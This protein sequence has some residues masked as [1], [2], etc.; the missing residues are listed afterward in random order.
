MKFDPTSKKLLWIGIIFYLITTICSSNTPFFWDTILT[1]SVAQWF[2]NNG[3]Q[4]GIAPI[5]WDAGHP[6]FFQIYLTFAW[7][8]FG[9]TLMISHLAMLPFL[10]LMTICFIY[11]LQKIT[12]SL[13]SRVLGFILLLIHPYILTQSTLVSYDIVQ[14]AFFLLAIIGIIDNRKLILVLGLWGLSSCS[15][16]G[17]IVAIL[18]L[19]SYCVI[20]F[21][22]WKEFLPIILCSV[23][24][25]IAWH[26]YHYSNTGWMISTPSSTWESQRSFANPQQIISNIIGITR[27][28]IDYGMIGLSLLFFI[29]L[30]QFR[31]I[32]WNNI[33]KQLFSILFIVFV[34]M[35][36]SMIFFS[37][38]IGHRYFMIIHVLMILLIV[39][40]IEQIKNFKVLTLIVF[41][42]FIS[43]H[44]WL[45]P[46]GKSNGWDVTL[47]YTSYEKN[48]VQF[49]NYLIENNI[50]S[51]EIESAFPLFCSLKQ[52]NLTLGERLLDINEI[53]Q[54]DSKYIAYSSVCNDMKSFANIDKNPKYLLIQKFGKGT[55][56]ISV[57]KKL[58]N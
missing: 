47:K 10:W 54:K 12:L 38:P 16:R 4:R 6:T 32:K 29:A 52:T 15:I 43:G 11:L 57:Y 22:N 23:I 31:K 44:F 50:S 5:I 1:S 56:S 9:K 30:N 55:T 2:Y 18:C 46:N 20:Y 41:V 40:R 51:Q 53:P 28:F 48:R 21:K 3:I 19:G 24:P 35:N 49:W 36:G 8:I 14:I 7:K 39:S 33:E 17:Q 58:E 37:N 42:A 13:V 27:G 25:I 45:Y 26:T 34:G